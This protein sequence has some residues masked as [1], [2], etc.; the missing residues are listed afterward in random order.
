MKKHTVTAAL[1]GLL[2]LSSAV[3]A[4]AA[5]VKPTTGI[6]VWVDGKKEAYKIAPIVRNKQVL[7]P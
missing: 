6:Q 7:I 2:V 5:E 1:A 4:L 3:P